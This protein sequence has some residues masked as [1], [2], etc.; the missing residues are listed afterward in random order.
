MKTDPVII[1]GS[2][3][4][5]CRSNLVIDST[6]TDSMMKCTIAE[7]DYNDEKARNT[8]FQEKHKKIL[9]G[10]VLPRMKDEERLKAL[11]KSDLLRK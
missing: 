1:K 7:C 9:V 6:G 3:C 8:Y 11:L 2:I 10:E 4:P 5:F